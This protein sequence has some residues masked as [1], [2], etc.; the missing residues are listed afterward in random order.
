MHSG[1]AYPSC[2]RLSRHTGRVDLANLDWQ[3][4][5][6]GG[7]DVFCQ[8]YMNERAMDDPVLCKEGA[9]RAQWPTS[10]VHP[11]I[12]AYEGEVGKLPIELYIERLRQADTVGF[13]VYLSHHL[14]EDGYRALGHA[15]RTLE[16]AR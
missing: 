1:P 4:W 9:W 7:F 3:S 2:G 5:R 15:I 14:D 13:S 12:G 6:D 16:I 10:R 11:T 8:A